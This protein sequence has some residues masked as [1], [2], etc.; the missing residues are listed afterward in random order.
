[1]LASSSKK[2]F[3]N[4]SFYVLY[5]YIVSI[6]QK[7]YSI[8]FLSISKHEYISILDLGKKNYKKHKMNSNKVETAIGAS[9]IQIAQIQ[10]F[11]VL[12]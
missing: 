1:M 3:Y 9:L 5:F 4:L 10:P 12:W 2:Q 8:L 6:T 7:L 11:S